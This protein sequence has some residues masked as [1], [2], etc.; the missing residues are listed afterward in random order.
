M[1]RTEPLITAEEFERMPSSERYELV[2][3][4]LVPMS[5]VNVEHG[6]IV[7]Q[8]GYLLK[9]HLKNRPEGVAVVET[10]FTIAR[11]PDTVRGPDVAFIRSDRMPPPASRRGFPVMAPDA[12]FEVLSPEDRPG[13]VRKKVAE[14]LASGVGLVVVVAPDDRTVIVHRP[15]T[16]PV[17]LRN[18]GEVLDMGDAIPGFTCTVDEIFE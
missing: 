6:R 14:Y 4:R 17:T 11:N 15:G 9:A 18:D 8:L 10:G 7:L 12:V 3:G 1:S 2:E 13:E 5:P 16:Q